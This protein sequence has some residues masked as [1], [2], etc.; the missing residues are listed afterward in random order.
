MAGR[1]DHLTLLRSLDRIVSS[2]DSPRCCLISI[3]SLH[4]TLHFSWVLC[5][6]YGQLDNVRLQDYTSYLSSSSA[7]SSSENALLYHLPVTAS[8]GLP[9]RPSLQNVGMYRHIISPSSEFLRNLS[10]AKALVYRR[11]VLAAPGLP[12]SPLPDPGRPR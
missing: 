5:N 9:P 7:A 6:K 11:A 1:Q 4:V 3:F 8:S 10:L 12:H 2:S